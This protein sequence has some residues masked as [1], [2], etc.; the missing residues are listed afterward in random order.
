MGGDDAPLMGN[1]EIVQQ[2]G[3]MTHGRPIGLAAH[4]DPD[5]RR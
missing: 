5:E 2:L 1:A 4:D 3:G